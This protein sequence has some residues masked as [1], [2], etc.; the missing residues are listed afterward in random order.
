MRVLMTKPI[1]KARYRR[2]AAGRRSKF[3]DKLVEDLKR[4]GIE[5]LYEPFFMRYRPQAA[6]RY[7]P[8]IVLPNGIIIE[9]KG[10][11]F[12]EDRTKHLIIKQENP[13]LDIRF[14]FQ[15][16]NNKISPASK[17]TYAGWCKRWGFPYTEKSIPE[18]WLK[19]PPQA[20]RLKAIE[21]VAVEINK[22]KQTKK[23]KRER[24]IYE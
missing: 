7:T 17:T 18:T 15:R 23:G 21:A 24:E 20:A 12:P 16:S 1:F 13:E 19:E 8:D 9:A 22:S 5:A 10:Y 2:T 3:E 11:F 4:Q 6:K 14:V